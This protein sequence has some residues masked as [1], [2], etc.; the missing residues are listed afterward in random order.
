MCSV[1]AS[2]RRV[3]AR[4]WG[5]GSPAGSRLSPGTL[6]DGFGDDCGSRLPAVSWTELH[7]PRALDSVAI[8]VVGPARVVP[9]TPGVVARS[10]F[11]VGWGRENSRPAGRAC[12]VGSAFRGTRYT[13][14]AVR[15][16]SAG[17]S[18]P[19]TADAIRGTGMP[20][21]SVAGPAPFRGATGLVKPFA[22]ANLCANGTSAGCG[23]DAR[24]SGCARVAANWRLCRARLRTSFF[25]SLVATEESPSDSSSAVS[26][27]ASASRVLSSRTGLIPRRIRKRRP[28]RRKRSSRSSGGRSD[29]LT[30]SRAAFLP[31]RDRSAIAG[32]LAS[33]G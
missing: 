28:P 16:E 30:G 7:T 1:S 25:Q 6:V 14:D 10:P 23:D 18:V 24:A 11:L 20:W 4:S 26:S 31:F 15:S 2:W 17:S 19:L 13:S 29:C 27:D 8:S 32:S 9:T 21:A 12:T 33:S 22:A 5:L 3:P